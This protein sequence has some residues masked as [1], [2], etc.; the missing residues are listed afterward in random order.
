VLVKNDLRS[1]IVLQT[2]GQNAHRA[3]RRFGGAARR[4]E[5]GFATAPLVASA[6]S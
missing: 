4:E 2:D 3:R 5:F 1:R 6:A